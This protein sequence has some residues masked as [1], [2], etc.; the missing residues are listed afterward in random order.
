MRRLILL[1]LE[2]LG[3]AQSVIGRE[4]EL[5][6]NLSIEIPDGFLQSVY[7]GGIR[8]TDGRNDF[9]FIPGIDTVKYDKQKCIDKMHEYAF[10]LKDFIE[11]DKKSEGAFS[12]AEDYTERYMYDVKDKSRIVIRTA[13]AN[14]I[15][16]LLAY[17]NPEGLDIIFYNQV[18]SSIR[19]SGSWWQRLKT[20]F[21]K[22]PLIILLMPTL[23]CFA[24]GILAMFIQ[25][26]L[27]AL[28]ILVLM[29]IVGWPLMTDWTVGIV[30]YIGWTLLIW[31]F[32][33]LD[34]KDFL[35]LTQAVGN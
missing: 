4:V 27:V 13:F 25:K 5:P 15:P 2:L 32:L 29:Y 21:L 11:Y 17:R 8:W 26:K 19:F 1:I 33:K 3:I 24:G 20:D 34:F 14:D 7:A 6:N 35:E 10:D 22:A 18:V 28:G 16:Y 23:L 30:F 31:I 12:I 9:Y